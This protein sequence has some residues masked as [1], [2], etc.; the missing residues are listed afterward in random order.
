M[1][2]IPTLSVFFPLQQ[3]ARYKGAYG[4]RGSGKSHFFA[5]LLVARALNQPGLRWVCIREIQKSLEQSVKRTIEDKIA[6]LRV[7]PAFRVKASEIETPGGGLIIFQGMQN[8]TADSIKS[9]E[10]FDGAW[11]EEA[12]ALSAKSLRLLRPTIRKPG[13]ELWFSWNPE[14]PE[15]PVDLLLRGEHRIDGALA[16]EVNWRHNRWLPQELKDERRSD[17]KRGAE[18][19]E[20]VWEG[21]YR[22]ISEAVIF[23]G[24]TRIEAFE[25]P[26]D[27]RFFFG[28][29]WG[30][31]SDPT[32]LVRAFIK[33]DILF[34]D[35]EAFGYQAGLDEIPVLF[36]R[37]PLSRCWPIKADSARPETIRHIRGHGFNI[38]AAAKWPGSVEDGI[39][40]LKRFKRI[41]LHERCSHLARECRLY[42]YQIDRQTDQ[43]LPVIVDEHNHGWDALRYAL[44]GYIK[45]RAPARGADINIYA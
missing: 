19:Y 26:A 7:G 8:H 1:L 24:S 3:P 32:V 35:Y 22:S 10:G 45:R 43:V 17:L 9:L 18:D 2:K 15:D 14:D 30:F 4:G 23:A 41:V 12:Q 20:H 39:A 33:D 16:V 13:S 21:A 11:V 36:D 31:A 42:S 34:V 27:A 6:A 38:S 37:V 5:G 40:H 28:A 29:D 44:D 25:A